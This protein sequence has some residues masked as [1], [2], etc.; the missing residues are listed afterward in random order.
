MS[1]SGRLA[2]TYIT[3]ATAIITIDG[4]NFITDPVFSPAGTEF[5]NTEGLFNKPGILEYMGFAEPPPPPHEKLL[6]DPAMR[7]QE[8]PP[9]DC[10][11]LSHE[12]HLDNLDDE[13]RKLLD[14]RKVFT[15]I[16]GA[17][18][19]QPRPGVR[20]LAPWE[21]TTTVIGGK[22]FT[23][24]GT[25]CKHYPGGEVTGFVIE[26]PSFG[27]HSSGLPNAVYFSGDTVYIDE[28]ADIGKKWHIKAAV[29]NLGAAKVEFPALGTVQI[30]LDGKQAARL[31]RDIGADLMVPLHFESWE[32]FTE[33]KWENMKAFAE[34]GIENEVRWLTPGVSTKIF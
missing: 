1:S 23:I 19:L 16:D 28:L 34:E 7:L 12:D 32:H 31:F 17:K 29:L 3:T 30:T 26:T 2:I 33:G 20:G 15:T 24:T 10:V 18:N 4:V 13:G 27:T 9:I 6:A 8:L 14:A 21:K 22:S 11:L 5:D 25:P